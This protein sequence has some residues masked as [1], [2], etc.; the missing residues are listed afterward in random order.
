MWRLLLLRRLLPL[1]P[2]LL[3]LLPLLPLPLLLLACQ[4]PVLV[5]LLLLALAQLLLE[6]RI[7]LPQ[8]AVQVAPRP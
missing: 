8:H 7:A 1:L 3:P 6:L 5:A 4:G 2:R